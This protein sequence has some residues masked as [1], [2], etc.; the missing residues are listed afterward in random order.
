MRTATHL[1]DLLDVLLRLL[2]VVVERFRAA[3]LGL[4]VAARLGRR[5]GARVGDVGLELEQLEARR[6][7]G[8]LDEE[9]CGEAGHQLTSGKEDI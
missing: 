7:E 1:L 9:V 4:G 2:D 8:R 3:L 6:L 5:R